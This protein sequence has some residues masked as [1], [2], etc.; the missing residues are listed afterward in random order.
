MQFECS[1]SLTSISLPQ[2]TNVESGQRAWIKHYLINLRSWLRCHLPLKSMSTM[3]RRFDGITQP[4]T[5]L[6]VKHFTFRLVTLE[7]SCWNIKYYYVSSPLIDTQKGLVHVCRLS[8]LSGCLFGIITCTWKV[9]VEFVCCD[10]FRSDDSWT[11][12]GCP[13][14]GGSKLYMATHGYSGRVFYFSFLMSLAIW[15]Q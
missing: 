7:S 14:C 5:P 12:A 9:P 6:I 3:F 4:T 8:K 13:T 1:W 10:A 11:V 2:K 15:I